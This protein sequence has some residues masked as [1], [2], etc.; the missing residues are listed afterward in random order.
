MIIDNRYVLFGLC[1]EGGGWWLLVYHT[2]DDII[3]LE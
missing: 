3:M 2:D 1:D